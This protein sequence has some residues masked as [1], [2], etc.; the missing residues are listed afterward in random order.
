MGKG[1]GK[2][3]GK[4][5]R[6]RALWGKARQNRKSPGVFMDEGDEAA[7]L[8]HVGEF[9]SFEL[10]ESPDLGLLVGLV[11]RFNCRP[12]S[13]LFRYSISLVPANQ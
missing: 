5:N 8:C 6:D 1:H 11:I 12:P 2:V 4:S 7:S 10:I 9:C 3:P 13:V